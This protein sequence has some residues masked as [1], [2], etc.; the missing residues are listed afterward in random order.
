M[1]KILG[2]MLI[3]AFAVTACGGTDRPAKVVRN[4]YK[5]IE[6]KDAN[7]IN[8]VM[9]EEAAPRMLMYAEKAQGSIERQGKI[10][11]TEEKIN[12]DKAVVT[13]TFEDGTT[14][15]YDL[16]KVDGRW[17]ITMTGK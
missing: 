14:G 3:I 4:L 9:T 8:E 17:K 15:E 7:K 1:K 11:K 6:E 16:V 10:V 5:A 2:I 13:V 12:G